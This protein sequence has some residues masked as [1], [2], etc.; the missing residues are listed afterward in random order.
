ME[1]YK[2]KVT[3]QVVTHIMETYGQ[4]PEF[5]WA[6]DNDTAAIRHPKTKKWFAALMMRLP[7]EKLGISG[8]GKVDVL[9]LK[10]NP[11]AYLVDNEHIF[12]AYHMN[13]EHWIS[14]VLDDTTNQVELFF[15][16]DESYRLVGPKRK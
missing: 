8:G 6:G 10:R 11:A 7:K 9:N 2:N 12:P 5:L 3:K 13:K 14:V 1:R 15:L 16:I 4:Q